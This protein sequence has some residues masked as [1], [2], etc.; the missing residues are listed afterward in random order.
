ML[1]LAAAAKVVGDGPVAC[2]SLAEETK[3]TNIH[4]DKNETYEE[5]KYEP[6]IWCSWHTTDIKLEVCKTLCIFPA[7]NTTSH[8]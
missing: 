7:E 6:A 2:S 4:R 3:R 5:L 1:L 8:K